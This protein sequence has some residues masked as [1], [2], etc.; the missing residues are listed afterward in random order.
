MRSLRADDP[1]RIG[2]YR[3]LGRLGEGGMGS[4]YLA[5]SPRGRTV[6]VKLVRPELAGHAEFRHRFEQEVGAAR[7]V[8]GEWT[9]PVLDADTEADPPWV[10]TGYIPGITLYEAVADRGT[11]L[12]ARTLRILANRLARALGAVHEAGLVHRDVKPSNILVTIDGPRVID[13]GI[14]RALETVADAHLT[15]TG[16]VV[17]SPGFMSPEQVRGDRVTGSSDIFSLG[18]VLAFAATGRTP[19]GGDGAAGHVQLYR[20]TQEEPDL[21]GVPGELRG[22]VADCLAKPAAQRPGLSEILDRTADPEDEPGPGTSGAETAEPWLPAGLV[23]RLG[24][25]AARLLD[26]EVPGAR[27]AAARVAEAP[28]VPP[29]PGAGH[30]ESPE[31][32]PPAAP[33]APQPKERATGTDGPDPAGAEAAATAATGSPATA[34]TPSDPAGTDFAAAPAPGDTPASGDPAASGAG[35]AAAEGGETASGAGAPPPAP[36]EAQMHGMLTVTGPPTAPAGPHPPHGG[37]PPGP[38]R[39]ATPGYT[40]HGPAAARPERAHRRGMLLG[41]LGVVLAL[42]SGLGTFVALRVYDNGGDAARQQPDPAVKASPG[43]GSRTPSPE[44]I[45]SPAPDGALPRGYL[46]A[47]QGSVQ[48]A[49]G[50][51]ITRRFEIRQGEQG[52]VVAK[53][54]NIR[55]DMMCEGE[56]TLVAFEGAD[57]GLRITSRIT[58]SHPASRTCSPYQEQTLR[59]RADGTLSWIY[60][61]GSLSAKLRK[62]GDAAAPVPRSMA[63]EWQGT[64]EQGEERTLTLRRGRVGTATLRLT[65]EHAGVSCVWEN[66]LGGAEGETL[67]YGPDRVDG[68]SAPGCAASVESLR[69]TAVGGDAIRVSP[70]GE[71][72]GAG[73]VYRRAGSD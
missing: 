65:G 16:A 44:D 13:F 47:W 67:T 37:E 71:P 60:P 7:R 72:D 66:T 38:G 58:G 20:I 55:A 50:S 15:R 5:Q 22:L 4:V 30:P 56:A 1:E 19:F 41:A 40:V 54:V 14:A 52:E 59:L 42:V 23:A 24:R 51:T 2:Q 35:G 21:A 63:G 73:R 28:A 62:V 61:S 25:H 53:T 57:T 18:S 48:D 32:P 69:I 3:L 36:G 70:V 68:A 10:A 49:D 26:A 6:A 34:V 33:D 9:A 27:A 45:G 12:P 39:P 46:G 17:G 8:G 43:D 29:A 11:P 31:S 64:T